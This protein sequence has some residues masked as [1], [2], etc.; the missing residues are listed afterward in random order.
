MLRLRDLI[1]TSQDCAAGVRNSEC[2]TSR[3]RV[4][5]IHS[6]KELRRESK[7]EDWLALWKEQSPGKTL[8]ERQPV[9]CGQGRILCHGTPAQPAKEGNFPDGTFE[10]FLNDGRGNP[11]WSFDLAAS[12]HFINGNYYSHRY[13]N[14][15]VYMIVSDRPQTV[16]IAPR[17]PSAVRDNPAQYFLWVLDIDM[18]KICQQIRITEQVATNCRLEDIDDRSI[19]VGCSGTAMLY[20][21]R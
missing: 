5:D 8:Y 18:G 15:Y 14:G 17:E 10:L 13:S 16:P 1:V 7:T 19:L 20:G 21:R 12:G 6:G 4:L 9:D 11:P 2:I 3:G